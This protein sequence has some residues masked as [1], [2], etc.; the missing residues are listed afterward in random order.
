MQPSYLSIDVDGRVVRLD[1]FS[2]TVA[3]GCRLGWVTA[4]PQICERLLR[5]TETST[6]QPSGF[7]QSMIAELVIGPSKGDTSSKDIKANR[8]WDFAGWIRWLEGLRGEYERRM[9]TMSTILEK[10][11]TKMKSGRRRSLDHMMRDSKMDEDDWSVV[12]TTQLFDFARPSAG[13]FL[14]VNIFFEKHPLADQVPGSRLSQALW[15]YWTMEPYKVLVA[16]GLIFAPSTEIAEEKAW[17]FFRLCFAAAPV[18]EISSISKR[19]AKGISAF[20]EIKDVKTIDEILKDIDNPPE[21]AYE[22]QAGMGVVT[23]WC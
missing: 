10:G 9:D 20:W 19:F 3:P 5:I 8:G 18:E 2:K 17:K 12:E 14:W 4:S 22:D 21:E 13:M 7:V 16:P 11:T 6:Q 15:V 1:T 23:G